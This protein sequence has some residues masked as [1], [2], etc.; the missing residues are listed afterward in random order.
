MHSCSG[1]GE[2]GDKVGIVAVVVWVGLCMDGCIGAPPPH[3]TVCS[4][5]LWYDSIDHA[6]DDSFASRC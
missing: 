1:R 5:Y 4:I 2:E 3:P 6:V